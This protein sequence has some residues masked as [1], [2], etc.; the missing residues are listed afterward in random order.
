[1]DDLLQSEINR[2]REEMLD[3][4]LLHYQNKLMSRGRYYI[5]YQLLKQRLYKLIKLK[6]KWVHIQ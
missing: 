5:C 3:C 4:Q 2:T 6:E 1:M